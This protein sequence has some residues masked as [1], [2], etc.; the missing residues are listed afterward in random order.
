MNATD[1]DIGF[2]DVDEILRIIDQFPAAEIV[3]ERGDLKLH[4]RRAGSAA[5]ADAPAAPVVAS[6][7]ASAPASAPAA[8]TNAPA[9]SPTPPTAGA[10]PRPAAARREGCVAVESPLVGVFYAAPSPGAAPFVTVGQSVRVSD[11]LCIIEVMKVM[12]MV[13]APVAGVVEA[14]DTVNADMVERGQALLW[15]RPD[16]AAR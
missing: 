16:G 5:P 10:T 7:T 4:V 2:A 14:I 3:Y 11:D 12:N 6:P 1:T 13:K 8:A 9:A 15:I